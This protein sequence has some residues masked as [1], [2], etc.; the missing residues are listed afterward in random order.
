MLVPNILPFPPFPSCGY[1]FLAHN[2]APVG[3]RPS[4]YEQHANK[5]L[6]RNAKTRKIG[7]NLRNSKILSVV[8]VDISK[9]VLVFF[10]CI[11]CRHG[12]QGDREVMAVG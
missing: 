12:V 4:G 2:A 3:A 5:A 9:S 8:Q 10:S 1:K 6:L 11:P 7:T